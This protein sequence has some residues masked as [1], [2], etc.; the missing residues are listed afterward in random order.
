MV[1]FKKHRR[2]LKIYQRR[3]SKVTD[4]NNR[5]N[6]VISGFIDELVIGSQTFDK[7]RMI[8]MDVHG[9]LLNCLDFDGILGAN[10]M[11]KAIWQINRDAGYLVISNKLPNVLKVG[12][13][14]IDVKLQGW[15]QSPHLQIRLSGAPPFEALFDTGFSRLFTLDQ[16]SARK[17]FP[18]IDST[19]QAKFFGYGSEGAFGRV[20]HT[21]TYYQSDS[22]VVGDFIFSPCTYAVNQDNNSKI[23]SEF[24]KNRIVTLDLANKHIYF[25][26]NRAPQVSSPQTFGF[27]PNMENGK[28]VVGAIG[29]NSPLSRKIS[30]GDEIVQVNNLKIKHRCEDLFWLRDLMEQYRLLTFYILTKNGLVRLEQEKKDIL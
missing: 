14:R 27:S 13:Q 2:D 9:P 5:E 26:G 20:L 7:V 19:R 1:L 30:V 29:R 24:L 17:V 10:I 23:G 8:L 12:S 15:Q 4:S 25:F 21:T 18:T 11:S 28:I 16:K 22:L 6:K 3:R